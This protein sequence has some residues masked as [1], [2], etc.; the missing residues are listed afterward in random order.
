MTDPA[1]ANNASARPT[2][3]VLFFSRD[4][5]FAP[6][7]KTAANSAGCRFVIVGQIDAEL[8]ADVVESVR[9]CVVDLTP[10]S[11]EQVS[12]WGAILSERHPQARR[13]AFGPHVQTEH[14][15]AA[16][17]AGFDHVLPKGQVAA[18]LGRLLQ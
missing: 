8:A 11:L 2:P 3:T 7:V 15:A 14:F 18:L 16:A 12:E 13:I 10:L 17:T 9:A 1:S 5:F 6:A 4:I